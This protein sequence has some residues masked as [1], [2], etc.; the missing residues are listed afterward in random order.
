MWPKGRTF[1]LLLRAL[2]AVALAG[3]ATCGALADEVGGRP[4]PEGDRLFHADP[5]WL[6]GDA[7]I[8]VPLSSDRVLWLFGD[9][10]V[11]ET[12]PYTR[13]EATFVHNTV[14]V[15]TGTDPR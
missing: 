12:A 15:Q 10:F 6:G 2:F 5:R 14:A 11:D 3:F 7:A 13:S 1:E 8:S 9:S 4:Y